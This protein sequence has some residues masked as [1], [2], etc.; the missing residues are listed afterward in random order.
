MF[1][2]LDDAHRALWPGTNGIP[3]PQDKKFG[4]NKN[5]GDIVI[6]SDVWI[7]YGVK[8]FK[9]VTIGNGAVIGACSLVNKSV[10]PYTIVAGIPARPIRKRFTDAE[11]AT[12]EK[13]KWWNLP[14]E[15]INRHMPLLCSSKISELEQ[16]LEQD[17]DV[18]K[19]RRRIRAEECLAQA[20]AAYSRNDPHA[21]CTCL[22]QAVAH[23]PDSVTLH[24]CLGNLRFQTGNYSGALESFLRALELNPNNSDIMVR[25]ANAAL[26]CN[27]S[28]EFERNL[29]RA[30]E[31]NPQNP[32][33]LQLAASL[34]L[35]NRFS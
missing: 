32:V 10:E 25:A 3:Y 5:R 11:I 23:D 27:E 15:C 30:L 26:N 29:S 16:A 2:F 20:D 18:Q 4:S 19:F 31:L 14:A 34:N 24:V 22:E 21:A 7:G 12:L 17:S 33:A 9:G 1:P 35:Q 13:I 28:D 8:L 6:G